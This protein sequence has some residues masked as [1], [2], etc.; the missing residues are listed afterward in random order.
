MFQKKSVISPDFLSF[1]VIPSNSSNCCGL[2]NRGEPCHTSLEGKSAQTRIMETGGRAS[3]P[4]HM[5]V[6]SASS[7]SELSPESWS[8]LLCDCSNQ[9]WARAHLQ[10]SCESNGSTDGG[11]P[12]HQHVDLGQ[13]LGPVAPTGQQTLLD[14]QKFSKQHV[15]QR[16][17][18]ST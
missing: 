2:P 13:W 1:A 15:Q 4:S 5:T 11:V 3:D 14:T 9:N 17:C 16:S 12:G 6:S 10:V 18:R 7:R 8:K